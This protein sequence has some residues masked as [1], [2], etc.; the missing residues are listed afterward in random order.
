MGRFEWVQVVDGEEK[1]REKMEKALCKFC[2]FENSYR[3][4]LLILFE[5]DYWVMA[6]IWSMLWDCLIGLLS[7]SSGGKSLSHMTGY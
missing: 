3:I 5:G 6:K 2:S 4:V 1:K 7:D